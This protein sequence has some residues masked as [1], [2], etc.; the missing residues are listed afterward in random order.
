M[1][2]AEIAEKWLEIAKTERARVKKRDGGKIPDAPKNQY[3]T[4][5]PTGPS[6]YNPNIDK[7][8]SY[9]PE[10]YEQIVKLRKQGK[11]NREISRILKVSDTSIRY[12]RRRY[13]I[14]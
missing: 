12:W 11:S 7:S 6:I 4:I 13:N 9:N 14:E 3:N 10:R 5:K 1:T 8:N 2:E